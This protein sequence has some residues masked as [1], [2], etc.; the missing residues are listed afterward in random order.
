MKIV[1]SASRY[2][3]RSRE[4]SNKDYPM[5]SIQTNIDSLIAQQNLTVN[6]Q[7]QSNTINQLTSGYRINS[8]ADDAAG[9]S[10]ANGYRNSIAELNQGVLNANQGVSQLQIVDGGLSNISQMLDRL[11]TLATESA[12]TTFTGSRS[13]LDGEYQGLLTEINRQA[14]NIGLSATNTSNNNNLSVFIGGGGVQQANSSVSV[15]LSGVGNQVDSAGLCLTGTNVLGGTVGGGGE[16]T[17]LLPSAF[18]APAP[19]VR[20]CTVRGVGYAN[21]TLGGA[22]RLDNPATSFLIAGTQAYN[23][24]YTDASGA[25]QSRSVTVS[26]GAG[27]ISG[28]Q[29]I[30]QLNNGLAG[31]GITASI[32]SNG[33]AGVIGTVQFASTG[34]FTSQVAANVGGS[35]TATA[36]L[37]TNL[38]QYNK[39]QTFGLISAGKT[40]IEKF[41]LSDAKASANIILSATNAGSLSAAGT[42]I[43]TTLKTAGITDVTALA[44][45]DN[46]TGISFQGAANF[47]IV[48]SSYVQ[49]TGNAA[50]GLFKATGAANPTAATGGGAASTNALAAITAVTNAVAQL[51]TVQGVVGAGENK[52]NYAVNLAQSQITSFSSAQSQIRD[53]NV[54]AEAANLT[55]AQV[56]QQASIAAMAQANQEPQAV[57]SL[58]KG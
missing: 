20:G 50:D 12:S 4:I 58:L 23:F 53:A 22:I 30:T 40:T 52:L 17:C 25:A 37:L 49:G 33:T 34:Q 54:A 42:Y 7:F 47:S 2:P 56:L 36:G 18:A 8:S 51:G 11:Q 28:T 13:T 45:G 43:N 1:G 31:T 38:S 55:K 39:T 35:T 10:V 5:I 46:T 9:L 14:S 26:G 21:N 27:G 44:T 3:G 48:E 16:R 19:M 29:V 41:T 57:L 6:S 24:N 32:N 15:N